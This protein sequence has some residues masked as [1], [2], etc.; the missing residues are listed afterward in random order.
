MASPSTS[1]VWADGQI[2]DATDL[3]RSL[4]V[5][6][7]QVLGISPAAYL[8]GNED[9]EVH[10][11]VL[12]RAA[13]SLGYLDFEADR[14]LAEVAHEIDRHSAVSD[15]ADSATVVS[16]LPSPESHKATPPGPNWFLNIGELTDPLDPVMGDG[17]RLG[18]SP[19]RRDHNSPSV[20]VLLLHDTELDLARR[21]SPEQE[22]A[23]DAMIWLNLDGNV[24]CA[25]QHTILIR[26]GTATCMPSLSDG[27]IETG[28]RQMTLKAESAV[29]STIPFDRLCAADEITC[30]S[31][32]GARF[33]VSAVFDGD[34]SQRWANG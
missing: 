21:G 2:F 23:F 33:G 3:P 12:G 10:I 20:N 14:V 31:P 15:L 13:S 30:L 11:E 26:E 27:A 6:L 8:R 29:E 5:E 22:D 32:W 18:L 24:A 9:L 28:W 1:L 25:D 7:G 19:F 34:E 16:L 17:L 4:Q